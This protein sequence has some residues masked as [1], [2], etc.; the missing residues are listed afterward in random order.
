MGL[1]AMAQ[2]V[3]SLAI[4]QGSIAKLLTREITNLAAVLELNSGGCG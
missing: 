1:P 3:N 4:L 2:D